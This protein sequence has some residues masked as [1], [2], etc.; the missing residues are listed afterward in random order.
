MS[1]FIPLH[2]FTIAQKKRVTF[3]GKIPER[4]VDTS[5]RTKLAEK[6][7]LSLILIIVVE[8]LNLQDMN[9]IDFLC[10]C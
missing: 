2:T 7:K 9:V 8:K 3:F 4:K 5:A 10:I 6:Y 1:V